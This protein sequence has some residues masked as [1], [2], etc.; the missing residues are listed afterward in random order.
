MACMETRSTRKIRY[1]YKAG[2]FWD[3]MPRT[4][5]EMSNILEEPDAYIFRTV[6]YP[7]GAGSRFLRNFGTSY[8][9]TFQ[10][11]MISF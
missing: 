5:V 9:T 2:V 3:V 7:E 11:T 1:E 4:L 8:Q 10:R 6:F